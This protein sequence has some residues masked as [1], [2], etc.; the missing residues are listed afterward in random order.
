MK[1]AIV[2]LHFRKPSPDSGTDCVIL[3]QHKLKTT[4]KERRSFAVYN[5]LT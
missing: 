3:I 1:I 2:L 4:D 5:E